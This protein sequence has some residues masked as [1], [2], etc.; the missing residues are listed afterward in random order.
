MLTASSKAMKRWLVNSGSEGQ[1]KEGHD[2]GEKILLGYAGLG[3]VFVVFGG[4]LA[5][6][7]WRFFSAKRQASGE[8]KAWDKA[9]QA[10]NGLFPD[11][12][13]QHQR[14]HHTRRF[15]LLHQRRCH[16]NK[17]S[18][19]PNYVSATRACLQP[20]HPRALICRHALGLACTGP[21]CL[22]TAVAVLKQPSVLGITRGPTTVWIPRPVTTKR[23]RRYAAPR[24]RSPPLP[25]R[26]TIIKTC[27]PTLPWP[28]WPLLPLPSRRS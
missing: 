13:N 26:P 25:H 5:R 4:R 23:G 10:A 14:H 22:S 12:R 9:T 24:P 17:R 6:R 16:S 11:R 1:D 20:S 21:T 15:C 8:G 28:M 7:R 2:E 27:R 18:H 19:Q 3:K